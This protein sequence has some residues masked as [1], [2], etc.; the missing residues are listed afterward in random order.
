M[1]T[2]L[3]PALLACVVVA[4]SAAPAAEPAP[5]SQPAVPTSSMPALPPGA[6]EK[7]GYYAGMLRLFQFSDEQMKALE[8]TVADEKA[9]KAQIEAWR[10]AQMKPLFEAMTQPSLDEKTRKELGDKINAISMEAMR[11]QMPLGENVLR[12]LDDKQRNAWQ[13]WISGTNTML[14][15]VYTQARKAGLGRTPVNQTQVDEMVRL[16]EEAYFAIIHGADAAQARKDYEKKVVETVL[17]PDQRKAY[18]DLQRQ[19][20]SQPA[21]TSGPTAAS[22]PG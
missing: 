5:T 8:T 10:Q 11:K 4:A 6:K 15:E 7:L 19:A 3:A 13:D 12:V 22:A 17:T 21:T 9:G 16:S 20:T 14:M 2:V 18:E 1:K